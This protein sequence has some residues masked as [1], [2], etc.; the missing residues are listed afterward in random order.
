MVTKMRIKDRA[1]RGRAGII[2]AAVLLLAAGI[3]FF[4]GRD[5]REE[6]PVYRPIRGFSNMCAYD[7]KVYA[8][9]N[10]PYGEPIHQ[11]SSIFTIW[12]DKIYYVEKVQEV[13]GFSTPIQDE[14]DEA[15][16]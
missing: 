13:C 10:A 9:V 14:V 7:G 8:G 11:E 5:S 4:A 6:E 1:D 3:V 15:K 12:E 2:G 16:N